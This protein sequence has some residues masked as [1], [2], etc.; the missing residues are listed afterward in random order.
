M[1]DEKRNTTGGYL[2]IYPSSFPA[3]SELD[4]KPSHGFSLATRGCCYFR[5]GLC[6]LKIPPNRPRTISFQQ[7]DTNSENIQVRLALFVYP[8]GM[9]IPFLGGI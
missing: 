9:H 4:E 1:A 7:R 2:D 5:D 6:P 8:F 3:C